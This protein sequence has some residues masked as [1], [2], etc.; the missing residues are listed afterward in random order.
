MQVG[1][2]KAQGLYNKPSAAVHPGAL[3]AGTLTQ[4][5]IIQ[6]CVTKSTDNLYAPCI[7]RH[8]FDIYFCDINCSFVGCNK[9][10]KNARHV[11]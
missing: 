4:Y 10:N 11:Y 9:S 7:K 3:A 6:Y 1:K 2:T 5:N 8:C